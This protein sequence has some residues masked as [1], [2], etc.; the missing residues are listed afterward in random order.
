[1]SYPQAL[2]EKVIS[3]HTLKKNT[4]K[5]EKGTSLGLDFVNETLFEYGFERVDFVTD[6]GTFQSEAELLM[7]FLIPINTPIGSNFL[8]MRWIV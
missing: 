1:M 2:F 6:P 7:C 4:L 5:V 8:E 3:Q